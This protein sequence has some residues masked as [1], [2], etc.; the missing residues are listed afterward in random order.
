MSAE[1]T[2]TAY[3]DHFIYRNAENGYGVA[4]LILTDHEQNSENATLTELLQDDGELTAVGTWNGC[5]EGDQVEAVGGFVVHPVYGEQLKVSSFRILTPTDAV[6]TERYLAS[7][8]IRGIGAKL[9][10]RIVQQFGDDTFRVMEEEPERLAEMRGIS[11]RMAREIG[12][13]IREKR[14]SRDLTLFLQQYGITGQIA[15]RIA[16]RYGINTRR[17]IEENPYRL[18]DEIDGV[19]FRTAD[20]IARR[21]GIRADDEFRV[22][23]GIRYAL[24]RASLEG[25]SFLRDAELFRSTAELLQ[26]PGNDDV[27]ARLLEGQLQHLMVER[28]IVV[29]SGENGREIYAR[30]YYHEEQAIAGMLQQMN[31]RRTDVTV[32]EAD[33]DAIEQE[34]GVKLDGKQREAVRQSVTCGVF[35][36]T[37]GPGTGKTTT[38]SAILSILTRKHKSY[39]LAAPTGRAAKRMTEATGVEARTIHRLLE[40]QTAGSGQ[41]GDGTGETEFKRVRFQR[42]EDMPLEA[43]A[44]IIDEMSMVDM[45]LFYALLKACVPGM[46]LILIGD[47]AQ[48]PSVGPGQVL[49]DLIES[50]RFP[51]VRLTQIFRQAAESDIVMNAHR[52]H[53]G[54]M[55]VMD[56]QSRDFFFL[57][58]D[59]AQV[60][61]RHMLTLIREKL[62]SY[63]NAPSSEIQILV[64][65]K[66]GPL[67]AETLNTIL[68]RELNPPEKGKA[69]WQHG[70]RIW[71][72]GDKVMQTKNDYN[73]VWE[74]RGYH[75]IVIEQGEGIFNGDLGT[76]TEIRPASEEITVRFDE[77]KTVRIPFSETDN[78]DL[79]YAMTIHKSQGSEY[80]AVLLPLLGGPRMLLNRNLLYT[81]VT[82]AKSCVVI[83]GSRD[84]VAEMVENGNEMKRNTGLIKRIHEYP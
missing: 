80:P 19:G 38:L 54:E 17:V 78:L 79:A 71:R 26:I 15:V 18:A 60:I 1:I 56:N 40:V 66:R 75:G 45:H 68:Q 70:D 76:I 44:V 22:S 61:V 84:T 55:P 73:A 5:D 25:H 43:D 58:R 64:P 36:L 48:L 16:K 72:V 33:I 42:N 59:Q 63:V 57:A 20:E 14:V 8:A 10:H 69:E 6:S 27:T 83:L 51:V 7:G 62:P 29:K 77:G 21:M 35:L 31:Q 53:A 37:G 32:S 49:H 3:I 4:I 12:E 74:I 34:R 67:G 82:R 52:I 47:A 28:Q 13:Q 11:E 81:A 2:V 41:S 65:M 24:E 39:L 23:S 30:Q 46:H 50:G 9:A